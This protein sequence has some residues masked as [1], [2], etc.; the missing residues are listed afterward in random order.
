MSPPS[1]QM[2]KH[3]EQHLSTSPFLCPNKI[4]YNIQIKFSLFPLHFPVNTA[5]QRQSFPLHPYSDETCTSDSNH[6]Q[7][8]RSLNKCQGPSTC[9]QLIFF[10]LQSLPS[11]LSP[12]PECERENYRTHS[13]RTSTGCV[14]DAT[15]KEVPRHPEEKT[16]CLSLDCSKFPEIDRKYI[17]RAEE[18]KNT[19][20]AFFESLLKPKGTP[21]WKRGL[22]SKNGL[23]SLADRTE[24]CPL[25]NTPSAPLSTETT[26]PY[27]E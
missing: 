26:L 19:S 21:L 3:L 11:H 8:Q 17:Y 18:K 12:S 16:E 7:V 14:C 9:S 25:L 20:L 1:G 5:S 2:E 4:T 6:C 23:S 22:G 27:Q 15:L 13:S 24:P 10:L